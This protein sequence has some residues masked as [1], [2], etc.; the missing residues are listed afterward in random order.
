MRKSHLILMVAFLLVVAAAFTPRCSAATV[1]GTAYEWWTLKPLEN[2]IIDIN[3]TPAQQLVATNGSYSLSLSSGSYTLS[4]KYYSHNLLIYETQ[5]N[6]TIP[7]NAEN[8]TFTL[9]LIMFP[10][11]EGQEFYE[12]ENISPSVQDVT[13]TTT[14]S[15]LIIY[16]A[17]VAVIGIVIILVAVYLGRLVREVKEIPLGPGAYGPSAVLPDDLKQV[18]AVINQSGGRTTQ[19]EIREKIPYSE[20]KISLM[21]DDL[22][23]RGLI[24]KIKKGRGNI[25]ISTTE[26]GQRSIE[27]SEQPVGKS[28]SSADTQPSD[29]QPS[30]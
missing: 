1:Q 14:S 17:L 27:K 25:I 16:A 26:K 20:A 15:S 21:L 24:R 9:D 10:A 2:V 22:E 3:T 28:E 29:D 30:F 11:E 4:A 12:N 8:R 19:V 6:I 5:E 23:D 7:E 13:E 18:M